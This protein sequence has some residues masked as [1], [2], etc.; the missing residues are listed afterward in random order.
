M[1]LR[2]ATHDVAANT[3]VSFPRQVSVAPLMRGF[4]DGECWS[5]SRFV[6]VGR[7]RHVHNVAAQTFSSYGLRH[8]DGEGVLSEKPLDRAEIHNRDTSTA[9]FDVVEII[10]G[11]PLSIGDRR[12]ATTE[13]SESRKRRAATIRRSGREHVGL[14]VSFIDQISQS[15]LW[16]LELT[17]NRVDERELGPQIGCLSA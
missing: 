2:C 11:T 15:K 9:K 7:R 17:R 14:D 8:E 16:I 1:E 6:V 13:L 12:G 4:S 5:R 3:R 10:S